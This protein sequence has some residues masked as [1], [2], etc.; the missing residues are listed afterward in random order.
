MSSF[1]YTHLPLILFFIVTILG[2]IFVFAY[3]GVT[4]NS[5]EVKILKKSAIIETN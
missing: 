1:A 5:N 2:S 4:F 3:Y